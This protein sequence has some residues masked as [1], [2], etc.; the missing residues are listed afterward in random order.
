MTRRTTSAAACD[1]LVVVVPAG[2][3]ST[4]STGRCVRACVRVTHGVTS[5]YA[6]SPPRHALG[7]A[8]EG[9]TGRGR[10]GHTAVH[11]TQQSQRGVHERHAGLGKACDGTEAPAVCQ[12]LHNRGC[13]L[14]YVRRRLEAEEEGKCH[15]EEIGARGCHSGPLAQRHQLPQHG[16]GADDGRRPWRREGEAGFRPQ[17]ASRLQ[18]RLK[19]RHEMDQ[20][21]ENCLARRL[22]RGLDARARG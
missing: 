22:P 21:P 11:R 1:T 2:A 17:C 14:R 9:G 3:V 13:R 15:P 20:R 16:G 12:G 7:V 10:R 18:V 4:S 8:A 5:G 19:R 6:T